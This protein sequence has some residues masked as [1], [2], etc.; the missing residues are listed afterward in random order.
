MFFKL[1][2]QLVDCDKQE[3]LK[4]CWVEPI[5]LAILK[6]SILVYVSIVGKHV[7]IS[8]LS[9]ILVKK[10]FI[11]DGEKNCHIICPYHQPFFFPIVSTPIVNHVQFS[12]FVILKF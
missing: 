11:Q 5:I 12:L 4:K 3:L 8:K 1:L 7:N 6:N 9:S 2:Y 10:D